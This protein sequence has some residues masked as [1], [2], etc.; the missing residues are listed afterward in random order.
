[1]KSRRSGRR[2]N[3]GQL[4]SS[5][6]RVRDLSG[7]HDGGGDGSDVPLQNITIAQQST[8]PHVATKVSQSEPGL[9]TH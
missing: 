2:G 9:D 6:N 4:K 5:L 1:M 7:S 3:Q 8:E